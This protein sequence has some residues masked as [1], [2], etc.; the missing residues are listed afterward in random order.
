MFTD[1]GWCVARAAL[2]APALVPQ[3]LALVRGLRSPPALP[4]PTQV[5]VPDR[6]VAYEVV[7]LFVARARLKQPAFALTA[8]N[9]VIVA[10]LCLQLDGLP[11]A[12][13]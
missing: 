13:E 10:Q 9:V 7:Q 3:A 6:L 2:A 5:P 4:D 11:L 8:E 12:I 1:G